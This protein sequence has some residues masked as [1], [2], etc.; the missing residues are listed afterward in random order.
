MNKFLNSFVFPVFVFFTVIF[1][2]YTAIIYAIHRI[3]TDPS[4]R[5]Y[6]TM[7]ERTRQ[8]ECL[9]Q[10]VYMEAAN[11]NAEGKILVA[12]ITINRSQSGKF[13]NDICKVVYQSNQFS[14]VNNVPRALRVRNQIAYNDAMDVSKK[15]L[16]EGFR[17]PSLKNSLYYHTKSVSPRWDKHMHIDAVIGDHIAYSESN[18]KLL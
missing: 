6:I 10:N 5:E 14:W 3:K 9:A 16:L 1:F 13:P 7:K 17:L 18:E 11:Q 2:A 12:Q 4:N 8:I 15:V